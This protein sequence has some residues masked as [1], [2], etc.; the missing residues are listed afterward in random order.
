MCASQ[1]S[2]LEEHKR[3]AVEKIR[4]LRERIRQMTKSEFEL[5]KVD[6]VR[7][8]ESEDLFKSIWDA[9]INSIRSIFGDEATEF[10]RRKIHF[11][12]MES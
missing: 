3:G 7:D 4:S 9:G 2:L 12:G 6:S 5:A 1:G 10:A 8:K 11:E